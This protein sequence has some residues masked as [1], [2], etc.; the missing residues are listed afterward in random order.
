MQ[1]TQIPKQNNNKQFSKITRGEIIE[2]KFLSGKLE[3]RISVIAGWQGWGALSSPGSLERDFLLPP[4][5]TNL[6]IAFPF[7][8][9]MSMVLP[10][11][12]S[13]ELTQSV[14]LSVTFESQ[15]AVAAKTET[16]LLVT[17]RH[18][19]ATLSVSTEPSL[20]P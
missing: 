17:L 12:S 11:A 3:T 5:R 2:A 14:R 20:L 10:S 13:F 19:C 1:D 18:I 4:P 15:G 16:A 6:G 7:S 9:H 8:C